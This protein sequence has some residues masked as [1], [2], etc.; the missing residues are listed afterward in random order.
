VAAFRERKSGLSGAPVI[1]T[2]LLGLGEKTG[3]GTIAYAI[4]LGHRQWTPKTA[5]LWRHQKNR[6]RRLN[7][8]RNYK[9]DFL[10]PRG[11]S[12]SKQRAIDNPQLDH[13]GTSA[14][15]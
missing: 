9:A 7:N 14:S 10:S 12:H 6:E 4:F 1:L 2:F 11:S 13:K 8:D 5:S 15:G 3:T